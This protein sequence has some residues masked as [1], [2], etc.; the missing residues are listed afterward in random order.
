MSERPGFLARLAAFR[1][2]R[3]GAFATIGAIGAV[4]NLVIMATLIGWGMGYLWAASIAA[5]VTILGNFALQERFVFA[6]LTAASTS[7]GRRFVASVGFNSVEAAARLPVLWMFVHTL[8][9]PSLVAQGTTLALAFFARFAFH[10]RIVYR[11]VSGGPT[12]RQR[13]TPAVS[14]AAK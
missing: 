9:V 10:S 7:F 8:S 2:R 5:A 11:R 12:R 1:F 4:A 3:I 6:D 13:R 14:D